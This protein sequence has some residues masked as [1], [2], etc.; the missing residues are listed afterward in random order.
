MKRRARHLD[1]GVASPFEE[2]E[3]ELVAS[4]EKERWAEAHAEV[5]APLMAKA[6]VETFPE[7][8]VIEDSPDREVE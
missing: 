6:S 1:S 5:M 2:V 3:A 8:L 4:M 7:N